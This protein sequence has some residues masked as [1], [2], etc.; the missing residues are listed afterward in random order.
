M[1]AAFRN[2]IAGLVRFSY[3]ALNGF[4]RSGADPSAL[5]AQLYDPERLQ[6]RFHLFENLTL[7]SL[8]AQ[9]D[10]DFRTVFL[11]G[12]NLPVAARA[13][14]DA[15]IAPLPGAQVLALPSLAHFNATG[16]AF[17]ALR[18]V[19]ATHLTGFRLDDDDAL[20]HGFVAR[21]R[22]LSGAL[23]PAIG[24]AYPLVIGFNRGLF[25]DLKPGGNRLYEV[26]EKLP[27][28][29]GLAMTVPAGHPENIFRRNHRLLP[30]FYNT[31]T[32]AQSPAFIRSVHG[33]NDSAPNASGR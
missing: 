14:L 9:N 26:V 4:A 25:L 27:L 15:A 13:R 28:G 24:L 3:P 11:T 20:D 10:K 23:A 18:D 30:Q 12:L 6:R 31:F 16:R 33:D 19:A 8:L 2:Q 17:A 1:A 22:T 21:L 29:I 7:P 32:D 5:E